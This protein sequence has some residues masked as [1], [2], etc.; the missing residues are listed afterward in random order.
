[1]IV[2]ADD[3][4][5]RDDIDRAILELVGSGRL[6]AA[7]CMV[8]LARCTPAVL[9]KLLAHQEQIDIGLHLCLTDEG[10]D[11]CSA[12]GGKDARASFPPYGV[13]LRRA[14]TGR[15]RAQAVAGLVSA[16]YDLFIKKCGRRPDYIDGHLHVHQLPGVRAGLLEFVLSLP[17]EVRPYVR[18]TY[19]PMAE[20][21]RRQLLWGKTALIGFF[22]KRLHR[23]LRA[24]G[25]PTND[26]FAGIYDFGNARQYPEY[27]PRF[28]DCLTQ[29]NGLLVV[30]PGEQDDWRRQELAVLRQF[31]FASGQL[32]RFRRGAAGSRASLPV[33]AQ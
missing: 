1:M 28:V 32:N 20:L 24:A 4:G 15:L 27:F 19:L 22:G 5:M 2:C 6:S 12:L 3:Y 17:L 9:G 11:W 13:L 14:L 33:S 16:Q 23:Q 8:G 26:G 31:P 30:H 25:V 29:R 10:L 7:S 21:W 18:N